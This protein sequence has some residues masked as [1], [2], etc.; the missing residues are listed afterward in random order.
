MCEIFFLYNTFKKP[1]NNLK[2]IILASVM[3]WFRADMHNVNFLKI[4]LKTGCASLN[5]FLFFFFSSSM[6]AA[7]KCEII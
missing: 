3:A 2:I 6:A 4:P 1:L 7:F 5:L